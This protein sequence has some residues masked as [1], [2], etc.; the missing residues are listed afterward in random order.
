MLSVPGLGPSSWSHYLCS[1]ALPLLTLALLHCMSLWKHPGRQ[2]GEV[3]LSPTLW[4]G[5]AA[6]HLQ[7]LGLI[8][9]DCG[10][11]CGLVA[12]EILS[13]GRPR[14]LDNVQSWEL[15]PTGLGA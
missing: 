10:Y 9:R 1:P 7:S 11:L 4:R 15:H 13:W 12:L 3:P 2:W 6:M 5:Q 14:A 8:K